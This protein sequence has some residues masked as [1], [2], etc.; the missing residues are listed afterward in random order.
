MCRKYCI[1][2]VIKDEFM[3]FS[4]DCDFISAILC[5][6]FCQKKDKNVL[7]LIGWKA[8][9]TQLRAYYYTRISDY[10]SR[11][12]WISIYCNDKQVQINMKKPEMVIISRGISIVKTVL[13]N[14]LDF[15]IEIEQE[16]V[17]LDLDDLI[18]DLE[19]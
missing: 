6:E 3:P 11:N 12:D 1:N 10:N 18:H 17:E 9:Y 13:F 14:E 4:S 15:N 5:T 19:N 2:K 7:D 8:S 16:H